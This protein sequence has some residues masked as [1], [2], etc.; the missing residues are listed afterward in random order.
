MVIVGVARQCEGLGVLHGG[1]EGAGA[2]TTEK[3]LIQF[4]IIHFY[5]QYSPTNPDDMRRAMVAKMTWRTQGWTERPVFD[6]ELTRMWK[7]G[8]RKLP[9]LKDVFKA[10]MRDGEDSDIFIFTNLDTCVVSNCCVRLAGELQNKEAVWGRRRDFHHQF[11]KPIADHE[12][13]KG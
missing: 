2:S 10:A 13:T 7:E 3:F 6:S 11:T 5:S 9:Y 1:G 4:V 12:I 8:N